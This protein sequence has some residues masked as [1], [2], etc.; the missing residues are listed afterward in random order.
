MGLEMHLRLGH[1][2]A[3]VPAEVKKEEEQT[4]VAEEFVER[5]YLRKKMCGKAWSES[6][7][8]RERHTH[9]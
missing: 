6:E 3:K 2:I 8:Q 5:G 9:S 1:K 4:K 7:R